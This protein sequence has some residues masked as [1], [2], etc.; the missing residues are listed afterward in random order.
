MLAVWLLQSQVLPQIDRWN[1]T[2][3]R[4]LSQQLGLPISIDRIEANWRGL[5]PQL[6][7]HGLQIDQGGQTVLR[8]DAQLL[9]AWRSLLLLQPRFEWVILQQTQLVLHAQNGVL[10]F[11]GRSLFGGSA[12]DLK[13]QWPLPAQL[14]ISD[15]MLQV[16]GP[17]PWSAHSVQLNL[18]TGLSGFELALQLLTEP[19]QGGELA[20]VGQVGSASRWLPGSTV[21]QRW[22]ARVTDLQL[23]SL[24]AWLPQAWLA[25]MQT[26]QG[27]GAAQLWLERSGQQAWLIEADLDLAD[28]VFAANTDQEPQ[29]IRLAQGRVRFEPSEGA[30]PNVLRLQHPR[31]V[32]AD[33]RRLEPETLE[34]RWSDQ[35]GRLSVGMIDMQALRALVE[36]LA[37]PG[38]WL[39]ALQRWQPRG[40]VPGLDLS[41][42]GSWTAPREP[43]AYFSF[44]ALGVGTEQ[45]P[46]MADGLSGTL[47]LDSVGVTLAIHTPRLELRAPA[48][49]GD[50]PLL[51][52]AL[53]LQSIFYL[54]AGSIRSVEL[55]RAS[56]AQAGLRTEVS[57]RWVAEPGLPLGRISVQGVVEHLDL[58][59]L[60]SFFPRQV[61]SG[62]RTWLQRAFRAGTASDASFV[63]AGPLHE[64]PFRTGEGQ[65]EVDGQVDSVQLDFAPRADGRAGPWPFFDAIRGQVRLAGPELTVQVESARVRSGNATLGEVQAVQG[66]FADFLRDP[67][68]QIAGRVLTTGPGVQRYFAQ[69]PLARLLPEPVLALAAEGNLL[70]QL[71]LSIPVLRP[72]SLTVQGSVRFDGNSL[73]LGAGLP[74]LQ[75]LNGELSFDRAG[76]RLSPDFRATWLGMPLQAEG[77]LAN[78]RLDLHVKG[79]VTAALLEGLAPV[80][81]GQ[82]NGQTEV[83]LRLQQQSGPLQAQLES[84]FTGLGVA[85][86]EP[87]SKRAESVR[88]L[89]A[90]W[91]GGQQRQLDL[92]WGEVLF[93]R[94]EGDAQRWVRGSIGVGVEPAMPRSGLFAAARLPKLDVE[95]WRSLLAAQAAPGSHAFA[96]PELQGFS[97][98]TDQF[99][100]GRRDFGA[101]QLVSRRDQNSWRFD[102]QS[103]RASATGQWWP[104]AA[105]PPKGLLQAHFTRLTVPRESADTVGSELAQRSPQSLP[106][107]DLRV[108]DLEFGQFRLG[109]LQLQARN[110]RP[111]RWDLR[112]VVIENPAARLSGEGM[113]WPATALPSVHAGESRTELNFDWQIRSAAD[114]LERLGVPGALRGGD[115][116]VS[117][118]VSWVGLP[119]A[120]EIDSLDGDLSLSLDRG[121][122]LPVEPGLGRLLGVLSLQAL[123]RRITLDFRDVFSQG[124]SFDAIRGE[125]SVREGLAQTDNFRM[126]GPSATVALSGRVNLAEETQDL[127]ALVIPVLDASAASV[128]YGLAVN[129]AIGFGTLIAQWLLRRPLAD[130][131]SFEYQ[132]QGSWDE[133]S[134]ER[135]SR[136]PS[137]SGTFAAPTN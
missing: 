47:Q 61:P 51:L 125:V 6:T 118:H 98:Q 35:G 85:S 88:P 90:R 9:F 78:E 39:D 49:Y 79:Q 70:G 67:E 115:G 81:A 68:L 122:F 113:W 24:A 43:V 13:N 55:L 106:A 120:P 129:P 27:R 101:M 107:L 69:S 64:F 102:L 31:I 89:I 87:F 18:K 100:L 112:E 25:S 109:R 108:D 36:P 12:T 83:R 57:G 16:Q 121:Q 4:V 66:R 80:L 59:R 123:P 117:G 127:K 119:H 132:I 3:T 11:A 116:A 77:G 126:S 19:G 8:T 29:S 84:D 23:E 136:S 97:V 1:P 50:Q 45:T 53:D 42:Q 15:G 114:L 20:V 130:A 104:A 7:F 5:H 82:L 17:Q 137:A 37:L 41:W 99:Q 38:L 128:L 131:L 30:L 14:Q 92:D 60:H 48:A 86:L 134:V 111:D 71:E 75:A 65:F 93:V 110:E 32:F 26:V 133:P 91:T 74:T 22:Y 28:L 95:A 58:S 105:Q 72:A 21:Q 46:I 33:E 40:L 54:D 73:A 94:L 44:D 76:F 56:T 96:L 63:L 10:S 34:L 135:V 103:A 52:E 2:I 124:F 62:V